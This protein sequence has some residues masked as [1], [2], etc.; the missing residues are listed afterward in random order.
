MSS[1]PNRAE[2]IYLAALAMPVADRI[3]FLDHECGESTRMEAVS[4]VIHGGFRS[5]RRA[6]LGL[7]DAVRESH[8]FSHLR[9]TPRKA[10]NRRL[11]A[12]VSTRIDRE[13][14]CSDAFIREDSWL[15]FS[16]TSGA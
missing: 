1:T 4:S 12:G 11:S 2:S 7:R 6:V 13:T 10:S 14:A 5:S 8:L 15:R 9:P 3:P 16:A